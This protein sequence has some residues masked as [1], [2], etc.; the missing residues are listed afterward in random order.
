M[1]TVLADV[2]FFCQCIFV[3]FVRGV[4]RSSC[5][6]TVIVRWGNGNVS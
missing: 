4:A 3:A 1:D 5:I 2:V 6:L